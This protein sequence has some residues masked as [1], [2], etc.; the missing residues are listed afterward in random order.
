MISCVTL[1]RIRGAR[2]SG[3]LSR[4]I[5]IPTGSP[6]LRATDP[7]PTPSFAAR[8]HFAFVATGNAI[9]ALASST[10]NAG[11]TSQATAVLRDAQNNILTSPTVTWTSSN[12]A[13]A[14]S[15]SPMR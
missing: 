4:A 7:S 12:T 2:T 14:W 9:D 8:S 6:L 10:I 5:T 11:Q 3:S 13:V 1:L 15:I